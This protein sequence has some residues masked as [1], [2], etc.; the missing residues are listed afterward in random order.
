[1][2]KDLILLYSETFAAQFDTDILS[3]DPTPA[4]SEALAGGIVGHEQPIRKRMRILYKCT[5]SQKEICACASETQ[6]K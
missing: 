2:N 5:A 4:I 6:D 3:G 1:M